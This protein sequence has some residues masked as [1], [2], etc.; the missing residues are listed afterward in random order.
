M[1]VLRGD[2]VVLRALE[3]ADLER[4]FRWIN[5]HDY[6]RYLRDLAFPSSRAQAE[7]WLQAQQG[8]TDGHPEQITFAIETEDSSY[9]GNIELRQIHW[10]HGTAELGIGIGEPAYRGRGYAAGAM[11]LLLQHAFADLRL[12]RIYLYVD[13]ENAEAVEAAERVGFRREGTLRDHAYR[14]GRYADYLLMGVLASD[15]AG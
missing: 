15:Y 7:R 10:R 5:D 12:H 14:D 11:R 1:G 13:T 8:V 4:N 6:T 9:I 2:K 3:P